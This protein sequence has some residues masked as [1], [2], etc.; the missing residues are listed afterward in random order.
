M[1]FELLSTDRE[2][3]LTAKYL[4]DVLH[5]DKRNITEQIRRERIKEKRPIIAA[6]MDNPGYYIAN[7]K[8]E[9]RAY[10]KSLEHRRNELQETIDACKAM[11]KDLPDEGEAAAS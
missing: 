11:I 6:T 4:S 2:N 5:I 10:C 3:T 7:S 9:M 1:I 8:S